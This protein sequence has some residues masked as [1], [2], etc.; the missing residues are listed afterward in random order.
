MMKTVQLCYKLSD[1][2]S[3]KREMRLVFGVVGR[4]EQ[5]PLCRAGCAVKQYS[6]HTVQVAGCKTLLMLLGWQLAASSRSMSSMDAE[7]GLG[8]PYI[9][10]CHRAITPIRSAGLLRTNGLC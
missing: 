2:V 7:Q 9:I 6:D 10:S 4:K 8:Y 1:I 5:P 3:H